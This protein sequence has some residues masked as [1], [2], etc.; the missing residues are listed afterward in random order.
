M[1]PYGIQR[2]DLMDGLSFVDKGKIPDGYKNEI[3]QLVKKEFANIK[4]EPVHPEIRGILA[5][6]KGAD[7]SVSTLTNAL[8]T[9]YLKQRNNKKRRTPDFNDDDDTLFLEE[10]RRKYPR[11]DT[12]RY[13]PNESSEVSLL[14]IVDSYL[15]HQEIVL[16]TLLPQ[17]VSN[18]WRINNDYIRQTCT[19]VEE[20][21]IQQ[22]KQ[23]NDLEIYR[24]RL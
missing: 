4:R 17:T 12:S 9:E 16:D 24:K 18:Q 2:L 15:K 10:Y 14:G 22:R 23:I 13:I 7:N 8:Y 21:N 11:I 6:R 5:K 20:M 3:D 19:I 1:Q